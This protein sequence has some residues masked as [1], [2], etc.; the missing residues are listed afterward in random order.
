MSTR[1]LSSADWGERGKTPL[2]TLAY[3]SL[4]RADRASSDTAEIAGGPLGWPDTVHFGSTVGMHHFTTIQQPQGGSSSRLAP[5]AIA[6]PSN[7]TTNSSSALVKPAGRLLKSRFR[8]H[9]PV[10]ANT[11]CWHRAR[12]LGALRCSLNFCGTLKPANVAFERDLY[13]LAAVKIRYFRDVQPSA[14]PP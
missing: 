4:R 5:S 14:A 9:E 10:G 8:T 7:S 12:N 1:R 13:R 2:S 6:Y 11:P 3:V